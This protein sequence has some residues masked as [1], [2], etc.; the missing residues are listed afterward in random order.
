MQKRGYWTTVN[1]WTPDFWT[2]NSS[3]T[4]LPHSSTHPPIRSA[5]GALSCS[6]VVARRRS[7]MGRRRNPRGDS[8]NRLEKKIHNFQ[9]EDFLRVTSF[10]YVSMDACLFYLGKKTVCNMFHPVK[11]SWLI[12]SK[13]THHHHKRLKTSTNWSLLRCSFDVDW[14]V[15]IVHLWGHRDPSDVQRVALVLK[16]HWQPWSVPSFL[17]VECEIKIPKQIHP[18]KLWRIWRTLSI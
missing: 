18:F 9:W 11:V 5:A 3:I 17:E 14:D 2:I 10:S 13:T 7:E 6:N 12:L 15:S 8:S 1:W 16:N 4:K